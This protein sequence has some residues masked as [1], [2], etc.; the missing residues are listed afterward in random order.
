MYLWC[1]LWT[2]YKYTHIREILLPYQNKREIHI[3]TLEANATR[4]R[5][6]RHR[7]TTV[8]D[9][10]YNQAIEIDYISH[11]QTHFK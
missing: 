3:Y 7:S 10:H 8:L 1:T 6:C 2:P 11:T 9:T 4:H 5:R